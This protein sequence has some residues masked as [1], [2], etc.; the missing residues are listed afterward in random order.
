VRAVGRIVVL[1][2]DSTTRRR[3]ASHAQTLA[4]ALPARTREIRRWARDPIGALAG[5]LFLARPS[6]GGSGGR[7]R[8]GRGPA[9]S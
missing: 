4:A 3:A 5:I 9:A 1:P 2:G 6:R 8:V 7:H